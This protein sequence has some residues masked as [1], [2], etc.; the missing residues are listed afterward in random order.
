M[1][2]LAYKPL[3]HVIEES[4]G[5][6]LARAFADAGVRVVG[7]DPLA[8][9]GARQVFQDHVLVADTVESA[10]RD[11]SLVVITTPAEEFQSLSPAQFLA[12][13]Q[14]VTVVDFWRCLGAKLENQ[15]GIR[16]VP[17]GRFR[18]EV[19]AAARLNELW[20]N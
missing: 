10:I 4:Q 5:I 12:G 2:G 19:N 7:F 14:S 15:P 1:L 6:F 16:Y 3:S 8:G 13:K 18:E 17:M 11:A 9:P 20:G